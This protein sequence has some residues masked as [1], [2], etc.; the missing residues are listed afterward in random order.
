MTLLKATFGYYAVG[1]FLYKDGRLRVGA[2]TGNVYQQNMPEFDPSLGMIGWAARNAQAAV[3]NNVGQ[4]PRYYR[5]GVLPETHSEVSV[6]LMVE[7]RVLGVLDVQSDQTDA[8]NPDTV[9]LLET[10]A[11]QIALAV[12]QAESYAAERELAQQLEA[13][14]QASQAVASILELDELL[15]RVVEL[16]GDTFGFERVH[17]FI[18]I[19]EMLVFRAGIGPHSVRWL[20]DELVYRIDAPIG[21]IPLAARTGQALRV[22]DVQQSDVYK[23]GIGLE[24]TRSEM[25]V[26]IQMAGRVLGVLDVQSDRPAAFTADDQV[27]MQSLADSVAVAIRNA[28][29]YVSERRRRT[30]ADTLR[31]VSET[32][33]AQ[34]ELD[35]VITSALHGMRQLTSPD[36]AGIF[37]IDED[38]RGLT[39]F[40]TTGEEMIGYAGRRVRLDPSLFGDE[41]SILVR[42]GEVFHEMLEQDAEQPLITIPLAVG[43]SLIGYLVAGQSVQWLQGALDI[44]M[45]GS[46]ANQTAVAISNARLY[47]AQQAEAYVTTVLLQVAEAVNAQADAGEALDT[48]ARLTALLAGVGRCLIL[49]WEPQTRCYRLVAEYGI[50]QEQF[51]AEAEHAI[52]AADYPLLDLL[53][54]TDSPLGAG[55]GFELEIPQPLARLLPSPRIQAFPL[56]AKSGPIGLLVVDEPVAGNPRLMTILA[57]I[58]HQ[59]ATVLE[60]INLQAS[61]VERRRLEQELAVAR[62]I[63]ASFIPDVPP[64]QPGWELAAVWRAA[65]QVSG[66][67]YDFIPLAEGRWGLAIADVADKGMPAALFMAVCR[68]LLRAAAN[69]RVSPSET[70][71][72][73]NELLFNDARSDLFVTLFYAVWDPATGV[74]TYASGGHNPALLWRDEA[75]D[76][77]ELQADGIALGVIDAVD[78]E[79]KTVQLS[80]GD[81]VIG[82]T[83]GLTEA[84]QV[85]YTEWGLHRLKDAIQT[86]PATSA[87]D[88]L[89]TVLDAVDAFVGDAPQNDDLTMWLLRYTGDD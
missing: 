56:Q 58:A 84:M 87:A 7:E 52:A 48:I 23:P 61:A 62:G 14:V 32:L 75:R 57:G 18:S 16:I 38:G 9:A 39:A 37:L 59:T 76:L 49:S 88:V 51:D 82:Y 4:D 70:L 71:A 8:F 24:D 3:S 86:A 63:Q 2:S 89:D 27:L 73:V 19:G 60:S 83:D 47:T 17:I 54:V 77:V 28:A 79:S 35:D 5:L 43:G 74:L 40:I 68:T 26:P 10:L 20:I 21:L 34:L 66:D 81:V 31:E 50:A 80:P 67:F 11:A 29:L 30:M 85:D 65:R 25:V 69:T 15:E 12:E 13:L 46:L 1:I 41:D 42:V 36:G 78:L 53:S 44:E 6:P 45:V 33:A 55:R 64:A 72:R 22:D